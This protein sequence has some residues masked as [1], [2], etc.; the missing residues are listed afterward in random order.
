MSAIPL[1]RL[2]IASLTTILLMVALA[3][4]GGSIHS[5][6]L[7]P[8]LLFGDA[9]GVTVDGEVW[10]GVTPLEVVGKSGTVVGTATVTEGSW[11]A[12]VDFGASPVRLRVGAAVSTPITLASGA[13]LE[14]PTLALVTPEPTSD[15]AVGCFTTGPTYHSYQ[16]A[17]P[18]TPAAF[19][20]LFNVPQS[21]TAVFRLNASTQQWASFRAGIPPVLNS[22]TVINP[23]DAIVITCSGAA[24]A[25]YSFAPWDAGSL[26]LLPG[27]NTVPYLG[28]ALTDPFD[29]LA[30]FS[31]AT[32][33][34]AIF[35]WNGSAWESLRPELP[36]FLS[37][38][39]GPIETGAAFQIKVTT[40]VD[41]AYP[42]WS[43]S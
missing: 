32:A 24:S 35:S 21:V 10:D 7:P 11:S 6:G 37:S 12:T 23:L 4:V 26:T 20:E 18:I 43:G 3:W 8:A 5:Q 31:N 39:T 17:D 29:L 41:W 9:A 13:F 30:G 14:L 33:V 40:T 27:F 38:L 34:E 2:A 16:G 36:A 19:V 42:A 1:Q 25:T 15:V 22:L 28:P